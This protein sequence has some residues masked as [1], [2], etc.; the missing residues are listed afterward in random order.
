MREPLEIN[1]VSAAAA[2]AR[3]F[4]YLTLT[5]YVWAELLGVDVDADI[6]Q[7]FN[8]YSVFYVEADAD[9]LAAVVRC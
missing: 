4:D 9:D 2:D 7:W 5:P 8:V 3:L 6:Q 1:C